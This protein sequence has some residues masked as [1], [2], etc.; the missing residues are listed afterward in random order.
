LPKP[1]KVK[2]DAAPDAIGNPSVP[3]YGPV[4]H[5][6]Q[7]ITAADV[8]R[9]LGITVTSVWNGVKSK[10]LPKPMYVMERSP[11]WRPS[12]IKAAM[13]LTRMTAPERRELKLRRKAALATAA[14]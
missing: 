11:R 1:T 9:M 7:L 14:E 8:A 10:R 13:E 5:L 4:D 3:P 12:E 2:I 6:E